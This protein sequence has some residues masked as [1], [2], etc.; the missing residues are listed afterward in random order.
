MGQDP[1]FPKGLKTLRLQLCDYINSLGPHKATTTHVH[2]DS[3]LPQVLSHDSHTGDI[4]YS[5]EV[6]NLEESWSNFWHEDFSDFLSHHVEQDAMN[7]YLLGL[8]QTWA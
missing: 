1:E 6:A 7:T 3:V 8:T 2:Q 4:D 5:A